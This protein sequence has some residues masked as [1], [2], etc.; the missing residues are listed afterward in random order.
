MLNYPMPDNPIL[1]IIISVVLIFAFLSILVSILLEAYNYRRKA[2]SEL[3]KKAILQLLNDKTGINYGYLFYRHFMIEGLRNNASKSIQ[4]ISSSMFADALIDVIANQ[5]FHAEEIEVRNENS[6]MKVFRELPAQTALTQPLSESQPSNTLMAR[7]QLALKTM[8]PGPLNQLLSSFYEKS[9]GNYDAL[10]ILIENWFNDY[11]DRVSGWYKMSQRTKLKIAGFIVALALNVDSIH[12][13]RTLSI[14]PN[15]RT[16]LV[17]KAEQTVDNYQQLSDSLKK[18]E[19]ALEQILLKASKDSTPLDKAHIQS[20]YAFFK[21]HQ[22]VSGI[23]KEHEQRIDSV[24]DVLSDLNIPIGWSNDVPPLSYFKCYNPN[25]VTETHL[26]KQITENRNKG[27][28]QYLNYRNNVDTWTNWFMWALGILIS[29]ISLSFGA[30]FWFDLLTK[31]VN[32][33][34][35]GLKPNKSTAKKTNT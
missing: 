19:K 10:K 6:G 34:R 33:R 26:R 32:L 3:L 30:P 11:M 27:L 12:L 25:L 7:F 2:R 28:P 29:A 20:I 16:R 24:M 4:Y 22:Q 5:H 31:L 17:A 23:S 8:G 9:N 1:D 35:A 13:I 15:L 21:K 18:D 14:D